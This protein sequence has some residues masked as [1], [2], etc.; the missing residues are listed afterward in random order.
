MRPPSAEMIPPGSPAW[1]RAVSASK[2]AAILGLSPWT[3]AYELHHVMAGNVEPEPMNTD[4]ARGHFLEPAVLAYFAAQ[5]PEHELGP[6]GTWI[7]PEHSDWI[8]TPDGTHGPDL[9]EA[10]TDAYGDG[11]GEPG[12][13]EIPPYYLTQAAW[14]MICT[15]AEAVWFPVL[16]GI[17][18]KFALYRVEWSDVAEDVPLILDAV[19]AF[20][21]GLDAGIPPE[22]D[23]SDATYRTARKLH[24]DLTDTAAVLGDGMARDFAAALAGEKTAK[25]EALRMKSLVTEAAGSARS[26]TTGDGTKI[27]YRAGKPGKPPYLTA[28]PRLAELLER[29]PRV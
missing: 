27:A 20:Q 29:P 16:I 3:S 2:V 7:H 11:W 19:Q 17:G 13:A 23:G 1:R 5:R 8:A 4:Q 28:T 18:L 25:A 12:T 26:I 14:Q 6:T 22:A 24:P 21:A 15:G 10:K 9:V